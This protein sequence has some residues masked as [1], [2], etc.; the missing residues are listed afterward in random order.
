MREFQGVDIKEGVLELRGGDQGRQAASRGVPDRRTDVVERRIVTK[1]GA[2]AHGV[3]VRGRLVGAQPRRYQ[4]QRGEMPAE[5][6]E[7]GVAGIARGMRPAGGMADQQHPCRVATMASD[8]MV[9]P[10]D[11]QREIRAPPG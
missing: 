4:D 11:G 1:I 6:A 9:Y 7:R 10:V 5:M 3:R 2:D 8:V